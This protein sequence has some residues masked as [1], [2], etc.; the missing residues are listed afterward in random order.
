MLGGAIADPCQ[1]A[2]NQGCRGVWAVMGGIGLF[3]LIVGGLSCFPCVGVGW[4]IGCCW[5]C[6]WACGVMMFKRE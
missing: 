1:L 6:L 5:G 2:G 4:E 3:A